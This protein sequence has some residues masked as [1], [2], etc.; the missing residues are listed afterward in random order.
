MSNSKNVITETNIE[1]AARLKEIFEKRKKEAKSKGVK[2]TQESFGANYGWTQGAVGQ[3]LNAVIPLNLSAALKFAEGLNVNLEDISPTLANNYPASTL[4]RLADG[5]SAESMQIRT[6]VDEYGSE[7]DDDEFEYPHYHEVYV[8]G[9]DKELPALENSTEPSRMK[10]AIARKAG[11]SMS[12]TFSY[13][14]EGESM[15]PKIMNKAC[16]TAD[17]SKKIVK[18]G[19]IYVFRHGVMRRTKYLFNRPDGGL[20]IRS[21]NKEEYPEEVVTK[22]EMHDIEIIGWVYHWCNMEVW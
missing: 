15:A 8:T 4:L 19:K 9:G 13:I 5:Q 14:L 18:D 6:V 3:Y 2:F 11:A 12:H 17:A 7:L 22:D 10:K 16:V 20:T 1:D 21:E